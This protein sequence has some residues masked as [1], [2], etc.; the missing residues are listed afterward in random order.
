MFVGAGI[1]QMP[2][3]NGDVKNVRTAKRQGMF[4]TVHVNKE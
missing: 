2:V 4:F 1:D 3:K